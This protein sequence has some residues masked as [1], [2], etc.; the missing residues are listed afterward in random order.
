MSEYGSCRDGRGPITDFSGTLSDPPEWYRQ[1]FFNPSIIGMAN[2]RDRP[3]RD[4]VVFNPH[5]S[6]STISHTYD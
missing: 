6:I 5:R 4:Y 3:M 2:D 1:Q